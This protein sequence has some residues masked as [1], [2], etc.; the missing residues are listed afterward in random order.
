MNEDKGRE[1]EMGKRKGSRERKKEKGGRGEDKTTSILP[2]HPRC[3]WGR[4]NTTPHHESILCQPRKPK[5]T[6]KGE[7]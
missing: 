6:N 1:K 2:A 5:K 4:K 3:Q 7:A